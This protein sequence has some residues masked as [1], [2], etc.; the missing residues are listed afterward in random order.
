MSAATP[1]SSED[2]AL[3]GTV[4]RGLLG[5]GVPQAPRRADW[6]VSTSLVLDID[7]LRM[8]VAQSFRGLGAGLP[9]C[10]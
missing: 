7:N 2:R 3:L 5:T 8:R 1:A 6:T 4:P 10:S 9:G